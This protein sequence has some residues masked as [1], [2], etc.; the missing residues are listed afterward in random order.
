VLLIALAF[1][2]FR[3]HRRRHPEIP[4]LDSRE[5]GGVHEVQ[6]KGLPTTPAEISQL[7]SREKAGAHEVQGQGLKTRATELS[8]D[9]PVT[10]LDAST[11]RSTERSTTVHELG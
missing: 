11:E 10:E 9:E 3:R 8:G 4:Q 1:F 5:K 6:G 2:L 7:D